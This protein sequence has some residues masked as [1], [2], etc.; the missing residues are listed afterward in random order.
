[1]KTPKIVFVYDRKG[2]ATDKKKASVEIRVTYERSTKYLSTGVALLPKEW[3][4]GKVVGRMDAQFLQKS[5]DKLYNRVCEVVY[6]MMDE[7]CI[8]LAEISSRLKEKEREGMTFL[9]FCE[10]KIDVRVHN[11]KKDTKERYERF[12]RFL[13]AFGKIVY[14]TD[15]NEKNILEMDVNS[16]IYNRRKAHPSKKNCN[17]CNCNHN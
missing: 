14:F 3:K 1:M 12:L 10:E 9:A 7:G 17:H 13:E 5:I 4:D 6:A 15:V 11:L 16:Y 2:Q 8:N